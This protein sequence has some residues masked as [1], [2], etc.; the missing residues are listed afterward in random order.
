MPP[1]NSGNN[2]IKKTNSENYK[3]KKTNPIRRSFSYFK[4][5]DHNKKNE[6]IF[7]KNNTNNGVDDIVTMYKNN[8]NNGVDD[9]VTMYENLEEAP[10]DVRNWIQNRIEEMQ[11]ENSN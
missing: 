10:R 3:I 9:I 7:L 8:T 2:K 1:S 5:R 6:S 11:W 4:T